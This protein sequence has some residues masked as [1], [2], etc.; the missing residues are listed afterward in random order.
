MKKLFTIGMALL[1]SGSA[2]AQ[3][4]KPVE[5]KKGP[6]FKYNVWANAFAISEDTVKKDEHKEYSNVRV[7]PMLTLTNEN[8]SVVTRLEIDQTFGAKYTTTTIGNDVSYADPD[9]DEK[10]VEVKWAYINVKDMIVPG[11][12]VTA[13]LAPYV[14]SVGFNNDMPMFNLIYDAGVAKLDLAYI[15]FVEGNT[16]DKSA[17]TAASSTDGVNPKDD[18]QAYAAKLP[19]KLGDITITPSV[20]Y[21]SG[22][23][24]VLTPSATANSTLLGYDQ[25]L[26]MP[27]LGVAA[28]MGDISFNADFQ[29]I[30]GK[31]KN[32]VAATTKKVN[33]YAGYINGG[34]KASDS[35][36]INLFGLYSTGEDGKDNTTTSFQS[37]SQDE[38]EV[39]PMFIINDNGLINQVGISNEFDKATEGLMMG[40][41]SAEYKLDKFTAL[42]QVAY[43]RTS[44][45]KLDPVLLTGVSKTVI[46]TE[47]DLRLSYEVAPKTSVWA[48]G[49]LLVAGNYNKE[50]YAASGKQNPLYYAAGVMTNF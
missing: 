36:K 14:Y 16:T 8:V 32:F 47:M 17:A 26:T 9:G 6:E 44:S 11:L 21:F 7:R 4:V 33:A 3:E 13:G 29:Y 43:A 22:K 42:A 18:A 34:I 12:S 2:F 48:E 30:T 35:L 28:V 24:N 20:L 37:A 19:V 10:A 5:V 50:K 15:K 46:G 31:Q 39:G 1:I 38:I 23:K 45:K 49:A 41:F 25:K 40:G 27:A